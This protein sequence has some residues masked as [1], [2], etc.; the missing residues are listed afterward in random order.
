MSSLRFSPQLHVSRVQHAL[1]ETVCE[2]CGRPV[3]RGQWF[4]WSDDGFDFCGM[5]CAD[6][7]EIEEGGA[8]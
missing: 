7:H 5:E 2:Q 3:R 6:R 1:E 4:V 8:E